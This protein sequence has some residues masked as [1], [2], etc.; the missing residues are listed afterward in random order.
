MIGE[1]P[2]STT[3]V[4]WHLTAW[5]RD[6]DIGFGCENFEQL[7]HSSLSIDILEKL[8]SDFRL[9]IPSEDWLFEILEGLIF[10]NESF[11]ILLDYIECEYLSSESISRFVSL[12]SI[13]NLS[14]A[15]WSSICHRLQLSVSP[16][17]SNP[18]LKTPPELNVQLDESHPFEGIFAH[19]WSKCGQNPH[20]AGLIFIS[21]NDESNQPKFGCHDLISHES[22][23][24]KW[25][26]TNSKKIEHFVK[27]DLKDLR[28]CPS[29]YS[30]KTHNTS[31]SPGYFL[32]SWRFEGSNDDS[33]W[34]LLHSQTNSTALNG[35]DKEASF[36]FSSSSTFRFLRFV[37]T[38]QN[39]NG[40]HQFSLQNLEV[41]G[42]LITQNC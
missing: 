10:Q 5:M 11:V 29:A 7:D 33:N 27:I 22:K 24:G 3:N 17:I 15:I 30:V 38:G 37:M 1:D 35:N 16:E 19:L 18:R 40:D 32:R 4:C 39:S 6:S 14:Y 36:E 42:R 13:E 2:V 23:A 41:F 8:L 12:I 20:N 31:W 26:G 34:E 28:L 9:K 25:W 21:A